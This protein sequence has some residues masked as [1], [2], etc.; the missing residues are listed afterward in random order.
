MPMYFSDY[1]HVDEQLI[2]KYGA[3]NISLVNDLPLFIDPFL[4]FNS[5]NPIYR[6][7]HDD[8]I[9][10]V[11]FLRDIANKD[12]DPGLIKAWFYFPEVK[13]N[14]LG[15]SLD[16]NEGRG[17]GKEFA[18]SLHK[19]LYTV[20]TN[21]GNEHVTESSH[22]EKLCL[23]KE[24]VGK[25]TISDFTVNLIKHYLLEYTETFAN[26]YIDKNLLKRFNVGKVYFNYETRSWV[27]KEFILP[28]HKIKN[29][30]VLLTPR[31]LLTKD[32]TWISKDDMLSSFDEILATIPNDVLRAKINDYFRRLLPQNPKRKDIREAIYKTYYRNPELIDYYVKYKELVGYEAH[33]ISS[34]K[35]S[36]VEYEYIYQI[37][38]LSDSLQKYTPFYSNFDDTFEETYKRIMYLKQVIENNDGYKVFYHDDTPVGSEKDLHLIFRLVWYSTP[39]DVNSE[40]NNGRGPVDYKISRGFS[41]KTLVEFKLA[42]NTNLKNNLKH[43]LNVY[44]KANQTLKSIKVIMFYT[45]EEETNLRNLL[46]NLG[47]KEGKDLILIDARSD[48]KSSASKVK[49]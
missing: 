2:D 4:L 36:K 29:E 45:A 12:L 11:S 16:G 31:N 46:K 48:N 23:L 40:V 24:G 26:K 38:L 6:K 34:N 32:D 15:Y 47:L 43:Q 27:N 19:N 37:K 17:L 21:F 13:Q 5:T 33:R 8:I 22:L 18:T 14:W 3:F 30:Y 41:D 49:D 44:E 42:R 1:F 28:Y 9:S 39:S 20:F 7:L 25:D 10:Y 35:V